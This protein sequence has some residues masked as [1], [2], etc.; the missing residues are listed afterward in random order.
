MSLICVIMFILIIFAQLIVFSHIVA[1]G[2]PLVKK[3]SDS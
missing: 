2:Q 3:N 1:V